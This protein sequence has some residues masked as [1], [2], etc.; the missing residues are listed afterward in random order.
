MTMQEALYY[1]GKKE[2][3]TGKPHRI[4]ELR[5]L[6]EYVRFGVLPEYETDAYRK[7]GRRDIVPVGA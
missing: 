1:K 3:E 4:V 2:A 6:P 7:A 5:N